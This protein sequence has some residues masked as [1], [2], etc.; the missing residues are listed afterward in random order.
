MTIL[1]SSSR[2]YCSPINL[3]NRRKSRKPLPNANSKEKK[4]KLYIFFILFKDV[5]F[6]SNILFLL[7]FCI[8][9]C[10]FKLPVNTA[11]GFNETGQ[12]ETKNTKSSPFADFGWGSKQPVSLA[13]ISA[14]N[15]R[16]LNPMYL[17]YHRIS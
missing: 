13:D 16:Q 17:F 9:C 2:Q 1:T 8:C 5:E 6:C 14:L 11:T 3:W 10:F 7:H 12:N 15:S 4:K